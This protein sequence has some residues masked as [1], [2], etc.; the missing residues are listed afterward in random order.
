MLVVMPVVYLP[1]HV[2]EHGGGLL[3]GED[4]HSV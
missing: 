4:A 1:V 3:Y 2:E